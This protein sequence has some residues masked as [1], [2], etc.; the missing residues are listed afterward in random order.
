MPIGG[1]KYSAA[2]YAF[3][4]G[5]PTVGL[6][7]QHKMKSSKL[8]V[9]DACGDPGYACVCEYTDQMN[10]HIVLCFIGRY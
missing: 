4:S 10:S 7:I 1:E 3:K 9:L 5:R 8:S 6:S 2:P